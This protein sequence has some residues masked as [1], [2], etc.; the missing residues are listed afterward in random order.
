MSTM[1]SLLCQ[2][3]IFLAFLFSGINCAAAGFLFAPKIDSIQLVFD[4]QQLILPG[5]SF[6][7]GIISYY[8]NGKIRKTIGLSGGTAWWWRYKVEVSSGTDFSGRIS[9][10]DQL[11]PSKGKYIDIK[12]WPRKQPELAKELLLPLNFETKIEYRPT[13]DFDKAPGSQIKGELLTEFNN[14]QIRIC[15]D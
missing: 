15:S 4:D 5:E 11:L 14:G 9:V 7:I 6:Q 1:K 2:L 8:R 10:N 3:I 13:A 12:A